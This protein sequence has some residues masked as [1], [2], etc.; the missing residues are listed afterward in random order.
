MNADAVPRLP[1]QTQDNSS[2]IRPSFYDEIALS[3]SVDNPKRLVFVATPG[4]GKLPDE[5][6]SIRREYEKA[7]RVAS[8]LFE[9]ESEARKEVFLVLHVAADRG[10]RGRN[11]N[12]ED[13]QVNLAN[14]KEII[15]DAAHKIRDG[16]LRQYSILLVFVGLLPLAFG[17]AVLLTSGFGWLSKP[18]PGESYDPLF[19]WCLAAFW[20]PAGAAISVWGDFAFRMQAGLDYDR[21]LQMDPS[22]W[23]PTQRLMITIGISFIFAYL[24]AFNAVQVGVGGLLLNDFAR[25][26]PVLALAVGGTTGLAFAAIQDIVFR[27]K[28][29]AK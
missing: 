17:V 22:R 8:V 9:R 1:P 26:T 11:F 28:P 16:L 18:L 4:A 5:L 3:P 15:V 2:D 14:V 12:I 7:A 24:L 20:I 21:L 29:T 27:I 6:L 19:A 23:R 25:K 10:L 13:G